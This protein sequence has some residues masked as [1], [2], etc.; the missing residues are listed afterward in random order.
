MVTQFWPSAPHRQGLHVVGEGYDNHQTQHVMLECRASFQGKE[1]M[2]KHLEY[3]ENVIELKKQ[4]SL[5]ISRVYFKDVMKFTRTQA[6][7]W[8]HKN[9]PDGEWL[10]Q[11]LPRDEL[12]IVI[13]DNIRSFG[14][15]NQ[16][17]GL[18]A[19]EF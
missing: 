15:N 18:W 14:L 17:P 8:L 6:L 4:I 19:V 2:P 12:V 16:A 1:K 10:P 9:D 5:P 11:G 3:I 13:R 7:I